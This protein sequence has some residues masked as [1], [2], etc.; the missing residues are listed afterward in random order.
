M[1]RYEWKQVPTIRDNPY[2]WVS[3]ADEQEATLDDERYKR[4]MEPGGFEGL[5]TTG[6]TQTPRMERYNQI[7]LCPGKIMIHE[8]A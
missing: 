3:K 4:C 2:R 5:S 8:L 7:Q 1:S 6:F